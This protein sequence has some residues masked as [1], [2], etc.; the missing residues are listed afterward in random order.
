MRGDLACARLA[1]PFAHTATCVLYDPDAPATPVP[2]QTLSVA[3][4]FRTLASCRHVPCQ[5]AAPAAAGISGHGHKHWGS[6][7]TN[8]AIF[9]RLLALGM[10]AI[11]IGMAVY[12]AINF[13]IRGEMLL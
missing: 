13:R 9:V 8:R 12:A 5:R 2:Q 1:A 3:Q 10:M 4:R 6:D 7:Y 11:A